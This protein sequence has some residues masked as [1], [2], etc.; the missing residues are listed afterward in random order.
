MPELDF[1]TLV[2]L[3]DQTL[4]VTP[5]LSGQ[6]L[7]FGGET[8]VAVAEEP[9]RVIGTGVV[10]VSSGWWDD[11]LVLDGAHSDS[12]FDGDSIDSELIDYRW[13]GAPNSSTSSKYTRSIVERDQTDDEYALTLA[14]FRRYLHGVKA[15]SGPLE[16]E[17]R[18]SQ[19]GRTWG[20]LVE[21]TLYAERPGIY[22]EPR[23][24][25]TLVSTGSVF[26][27]ILRNAVPYPSAELTP[28]ET[29]V[30]I[31]HIT[32]PSAESG[33]TNWSAGTFG[34][35]EGVP[36]AIGTA[37][38]GAVMNDRANAGRA[39]FR[40]RWLGDGKT[41]GSSSRIVRITYQ[42]QLPSLATGAEV[43]VTIWGSLVAQNASYT[44]GSTSVGAAYRWIDAVGDT[45]GVAVSLGEATTEEEL[46]GKIFSLAGQIKP[47]GATGISFIVDAALTVQSSSDP[48]LNSDVR[49]YADSVGVIEEV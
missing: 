36:P 4:V 10:E 30:A 23:G 28:S 47:A 41:E 37:S 42:Q 18:R 5:R 24:L 40:Y 35:E 11:L 8:L 14:S 34:G 32:N 31:N 33:P 21:F 17:T 12:Y 29:I 45:V 48:A 22:S 1:V 26:D 39:A 43:A 38:S 15:I 9:M 20:R 49:L 7:R 6:V 44:W 13:D 16:V 25:G 19:N 3:L 27:D 46:S 2:T